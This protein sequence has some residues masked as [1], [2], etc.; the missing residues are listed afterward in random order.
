M[1]YDFQ[2][3]SFLKRAP[4]W[5]LDMIIL[6]TLA[7]GLM[8][9]ISYVVDIDTTI[10]H[11]SERRAYYVEEYGVS[12]DVT[13]EQIQQMSDEELAKYQAAAEELAKDTEIQKALELL[14]N[15]ILIIA[16]FG[17]LGAFVIL[18]VL[19]PMW[20][21]NGQT[22]GKKCFGIGLMRKDGITVTPFMLFVRAALGKFTVE[23]MIPIFLVLM[24]FF[25]IMS[26]GLILALVFLLVQIIV[27]VAT[28]NKTAIHD[29]AAC[30][31][32]VDLASQMI[33]D[34]VEEMQAYNAEIYGDKAFEGRE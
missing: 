16:G 1:D 34:S 9:A 23:T 3:A 21:K 10:E 11:V 15:Q 22:L 28:R 17:F 26:M 7:T 6:I 30:T 20:L 4:A 2:R 24:S 18:E 5:L 25:G 32:A 33:F 27:P 13:E 29:L 19:I 8:A 31:V 14:M 12:F